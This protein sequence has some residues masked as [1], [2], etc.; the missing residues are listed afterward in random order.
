SFAKRMQQ[1]DSDSLLEMFLTAITSSYDPH[2]TYMSPSSLENFDIL[3]KLE[4]IG[5]GASLQSTDGYTVITKLIPGG[6][7]EK[8]G[9]LKPEDRIL[10]V[11]QDK[12]GEMVDVVDMRLEDVVDM[13]R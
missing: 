12:E 4:L 5:I 11:G 13:I 2:T 3:M 7:A 10:S 6:P 9:Q 8:G 1:T